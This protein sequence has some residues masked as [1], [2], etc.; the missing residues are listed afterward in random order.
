M[1]D[2]RKAP[3]PRRAARLLVIDSKSG[4]VLLFQYE[5]DGRRW[6]AT[7]GGGL[8]GDET[9][10]NAAI[11]EAAE[12]LAISSRTFVPLWNRTVEFSFRGAAIR[13]EEHY[14]LL[15]V[16][17]GE[18]ALGHQVREAHG[19]EG[20]IATRWWSL[21]EIEATSEQVFPEDL[22]R[23]VRELRSARTSTEGF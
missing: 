15:Q 17:P 14:F 10:E 3:T 1:N 2:H 21:E 13:Q 16:P 6:W 7:P 12:E 5:D 19:R 8:D 4:A 18:V 23:R 9:F 22:P 11:R 20:I